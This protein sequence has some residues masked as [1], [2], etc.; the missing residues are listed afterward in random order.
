M[1]SPDI[2]GVSAGAGLGA[3]A[4][5]L[6]GLDIVAIQFLSFGGGLL[7]VLLTCALAAPVSRRGDPVLTLVLVGIL[8]GAVFM[9]LIS[10]VKYVADT[11]TKLP[12]ITFWL[13]GSMAAVNPRDVRLLAPIAIA[14]LVPLL[15]VRWR[16]NVLSFGEEE[17][18]ALGIH[19]GRLRWTVI[20]ASTL[21][22]ASSVAVAG[23]VGW[24]GLVIPHLARMLVGPNYKVL[25]PA[26]LLLGSSYLLLVD[27]VARSVSATEIPLGILTALVGAPFFLYLM[28]RSKRGWV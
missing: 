6:F 20:L 25:L 28:T 3:A 27:D 18:R 17:A 4:G 13:M 9:S 14:G 11:N 10:L 7:A 23:M 5:I 26:S 22:T 8:V 12:A 24:V 19:T 15:L 21:L 2:L 16:L 1:V